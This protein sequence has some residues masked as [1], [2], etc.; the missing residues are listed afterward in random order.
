[1]TK[2]SYTYINSLGKKVTTTSY[3]EFQ[4]NRAKNTRSKINYET[5]YEEPVINPERKRRSLV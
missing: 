5:I 4:A 3:A 2:V 1:M